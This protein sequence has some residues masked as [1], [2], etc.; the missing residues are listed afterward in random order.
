M[1]YHTIW[2]HLKNSIKI[3][4]KKPT[5]KSIENYDFS[6]FHLCKITPNIAICSF[7]CWLIRMVPICL[8]QLRFL[9]FFN[10]VFWWKYITLI[11][12]Q[13]ACFSI[14]SYFL[15][16][17]IWGYMDLS[18]HWNFNPFLRTIGHDKYTYSPKD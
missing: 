11:N 17:L 5:V 13:F 10:L 7:R 2:L 9:S 3:N 4:C 15:H 8:R 1:I 18:N 6:L 16:S 12:I 14:Q